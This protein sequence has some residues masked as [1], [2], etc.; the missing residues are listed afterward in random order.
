[1]IALKH[2]HLEDL[3]KYLESYLDIS[4]G[5]VIAMETAKAGVHVDTEGQHFHVCADMDQKQYDSFRKTILVKKYQLRGQAKKDLPRQYGCI[6]DV[7]S[8]SKF[9]SYTVKD[10]NIIFKNIDIKIIQNAI[11]NSYKKEDKKD[12]T[13]ELMKYLIKCRNQFIITFSE[14]EGSD[15][16]PYKIEELVLYYFMENTDKVL[17]LSRLQ[18]Y[19]NLYLQQNEPNRKIYL[20]TIINYLKKRI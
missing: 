7:R 10:K 1:M 13:D 15:I 18:Y 6:R 19:T 20:E 11:E 5:Y 8:E 16:N 12:L 2:E 4:A 14:N 17:C 3:T 9:L